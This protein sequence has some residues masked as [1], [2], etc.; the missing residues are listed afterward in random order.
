V[1][2]LIAISGY[3]TIRSSYG[4]IIRSSAEVMSQP[5]GDCHVW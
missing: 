4:S 5:D 3:P 1:I 2:T